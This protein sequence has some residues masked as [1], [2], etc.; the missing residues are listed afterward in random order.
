MF[1]DRVSNIDFGEIY[2]EVGDNWQEVAKGA[3]FGIRDELEGLFGLTAD[4]FA[5]KEW[6]PDGKKTPRIEKYKRDKNPWYKKAME[7]AAKL[8][9]PKFKSSSSSSS[10]SSSTTTPTTSL[11]S[12]PVLVPGKGA[13]GP[14]SGSGLHSLGFGT[15]SADDHKATDKASLASLSSSS[16]SSSS[17]GPDRRTTKTTKSTPYSKT[18]KLSTQE[19]KNA[20]AAKRQQTTLSILPKE[21]GQIELSVKSA[22]YSTEVAL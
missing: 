17:P 16:S 14:P 7:Q 10:S 3:V 8:P 22:W 6:Y 5:A 12:S 18:P 9:G 13:G 19:Q 4:D 21:I 2:I 11:S 15:I 20:E 1:N